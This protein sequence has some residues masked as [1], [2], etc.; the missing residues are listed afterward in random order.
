LHFF[1]NIFFLL[2]LK[3]RRSLAQKRRSSRYKV[4]K[5]NKCTLFFFNKSLKMYLYTG[6]TCRTFVSSITNNNSTEAES[7]AVIDTQIRN[8]S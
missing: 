3:K 5:Q 6:Q 1:N 2:S 4:F 8:F 7:K